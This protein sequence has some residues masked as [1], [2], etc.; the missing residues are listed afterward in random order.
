M[1]NIQILAFEK[2]INRNYWSDHGLYYRKT[3]LIMV[4]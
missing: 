4:Q 1:I 2:K 3:E